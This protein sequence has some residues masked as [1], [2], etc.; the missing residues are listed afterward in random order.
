MFASDV[1]VFVTLGDRGSLRDAFNGIAHPRV[2]VERIVAFDPTTHQPVIRLIS[3]S[4]DRDIWR[5]IV[6]GSGGRR[7]EP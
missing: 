2:L 5:E 4:S 6:S 7:C 1:S 3:F